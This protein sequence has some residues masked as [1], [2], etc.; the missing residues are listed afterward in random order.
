MKD[1]ASMTK[2]ELIELLSKAQNGENRK[3]QVLE[4]LEKGFDTIEALA[5][6]LNIT[7]KNVSSVLSHLRKDGNNIITLKIQGQNVLKL[8]SAE[9]LQEMIN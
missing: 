4:L 1:Y 7:K 9:K 6:E 5:N 8:I 3:K 2:A